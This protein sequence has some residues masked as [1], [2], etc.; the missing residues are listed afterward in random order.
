M[1]LS[2]QEQE[3]NKHVKFINKAPEY[4]YQQSTVV[5][6]KLVAFTIVMAGGAQQGTTK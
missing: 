5:N 1:R 2:Q 3:F 6:S 4:Q